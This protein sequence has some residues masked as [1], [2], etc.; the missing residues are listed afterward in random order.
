MDP[1]TLGILLTAAGALGNNQVQNQRTKSLNRNTQTVL[2]N[3]KRKQG[4]LDQER[5]AT[6]GQA[7]EN[8]SVGRGEVEAAQGA[9]SDK[10][11]ARMEANSRSAPTMNAPDKAG[12]SGPAG[13]VIASA[14]DREAGANA[15]STAGRRR[16]AADLDSLGDVLG[17]NSRVYRPA[18]AEIQ[19]NQRIAQGEAARMPLELQAVQEKAMRKGRNLEVISGLASGVGTGLLAG[20]AFGPAAAPAAGVSG[21]SGTAVTSATS[22]MGMG[23]GTKFGIVPSLIY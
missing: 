17:A 13:R 2:T 10:S 1:I 12:L 20:G 15:E 7:L 5:Q 19:G 8:A 23:A 14:V 3:A 22:G 4:Q 18:Y 9:A 16:A 6:L 21:G 11:V